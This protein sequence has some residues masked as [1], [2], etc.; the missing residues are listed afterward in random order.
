MA[1]L[2]LVRMDLNNGLFIAIMFGYL[3]YASYATLQ[4]YRGGGY[5]GYGGYEEDD[6]PW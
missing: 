3:A 5:G 4:A 6:R 2:A 1:V